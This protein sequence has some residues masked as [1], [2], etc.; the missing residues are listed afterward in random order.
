MFDVR[1]NELERLG[2]PTCLLGE[3]LYLIKTNGEYDTYDERR[4]LELI[5]E[6]DEFIF[7]LFDFER[8]YNMN[9]GRAIN[10]W[11]KNE[12]H[13]KIKNNRD[14]IISEI[15]NDIKTIEKGIFVRIR[16]MES[17]K[18]N[19][20]SEFIF[21]VMSL[22][23]A[24][25]YFEN[26]IEEY[27]TDEK[28]L[29]MIE[30]GMIVFRLNGMIEDKLFIFGSDKNKIAKFIKKLDNKV[31]VMVSTKSSESFKNNFPEICI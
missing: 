5:E 18:I 6:K 14:E 16:R 12:Y 9:K 29:I 17:R 24:C 4:Q 3:I 21:D 27:A 15:L 25:E 11:V 20:D 26:I 13:Q 1:I 23:D 28:F 2:F 8:T 22:K 19:V 7:Y 30:K 10:V 31:N